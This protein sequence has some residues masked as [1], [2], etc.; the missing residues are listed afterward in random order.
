[1]QKSIAQKI[2]D[3][4]SNQK[5]IISQ[6]SE[7]VVQVNAWKELRTRAMCDNYVPQ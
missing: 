6:F 1:M 5:I 2:V 7:N 3:G 4:L